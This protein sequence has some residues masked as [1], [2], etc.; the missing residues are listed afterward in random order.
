MGNC[1]V[2]CLSKPP[3]EL[4]VRWG[5]TRCP[6]CSIV[7]PWP[8]KLL[9]SEIILTGRSNKFEPL[10][11][12]PELLKFST[13]DIDWTCGEMLIFLRLISYGVVSPPSNYPRICS[14]TWWLEPCQFLGL[15]SCRRD[16]CLLVIYHLLW[17]QGLT[18]IPV[19]NTHMHKYMNK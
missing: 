13:A 11:D 2:W 6:K 3:G 7:F 18:F 15:N 8:I 5:K 4:D 16:S 19:S 10:H 17:F 12:L 1:D 14:R 9:Y